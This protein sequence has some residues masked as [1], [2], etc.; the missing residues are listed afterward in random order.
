MIKTKIIILLLLINS[1]FSMAGMHSFKGP[2]WQ[3]FDNVNEREKTLVYLPEDYDKNKKYP[4]IIS[5]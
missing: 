2:F 4:L 1:N 5:L 3:D